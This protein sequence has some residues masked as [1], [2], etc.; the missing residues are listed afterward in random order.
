MPR[1]LSVTVERFPLAKEFRIARGA[2]TEAA[3]VT[4]TI[5]EDQ[6]TGRGECVPYARYGESLD[7][8]CE[9]IEGVRGFIEAGCSLDDLAAR[10]EPGA[11]RNAID[12]ALWD[13][14]AKL[15]GRSV[16]SLICDSEPRPLE[17]AYTISLDAPDVM[18]EAARA[19][20]RPLLKIKVGTAS[21]VARLRAIHAAAP[22]SKLIVD[23]N[24]GWAEDNIREHMLVAAEAGA[25]LV[26]QPLPAGKDRILRYIPHPVPICADESAHTADQLDALL[27]LYDY[28]NVKLD[29]TGGLTEGIRLVREAHGLGF[30]VMVGCMVGTSLAMAP[31]VLLA[32]SAEFVDLDG[33]LLLAEDRPGGL[34]YSTTTVSPPQTELWG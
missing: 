23:A 26:E 29:K 3:V 8:V 21:D 18:A 14:R 32:Q 11:A 4:A 30:G 5:V 1:R 15:S 7:S 27:G 31:A 10:L 20:D 17:T 33:P 22:N 24:E 28:V 16:A 25:V 9:Q 12:C 6:A 2:K 19:A 34:R 13:L